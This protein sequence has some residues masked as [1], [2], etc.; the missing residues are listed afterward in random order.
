MEIQQLANHGIPSEII[1]QFKNQGFRVLTSVQSA[2]VEAGLTSGQSLVISAPTS[3]G[4]TTIAELAAIVAAQQGRRTVYLVTHRALAEEKYRHFKSTYDNG[5]DSWFDV[6]ISTGDR[7]DGD[8]QNG[9]LVATYEKFLSLVATG[10]IKNY[11]KLVVVADEIQTISAPSRGADIEIL[12][13]ILLHAKPAQFIGLTATAPNVDELAEWLGCISC[14]VDIRDVPLDQEI[15]FAGKVSGCE[16]GHGEV[17]DRDRDVPNPCGSIQAVRAL[18]DSG[19]GP[20]LVFCM[21]K[22]RAEQLATEFSGLS[23]RNQGA[24]EVSR[25]LDLFTEPTALG[26]RL[27]A[28]TASRTAFHTADLSFSERAVV[29]EALRDGH[30]DVVFATP[31]LAAGVNLPIRSVVFDSFQRPWMDEP[32]LSQSE[33]ANM[34]GRAGRLG[35]HDRGSM[36]M[37][38]TNRTEYAKAYQYVVDQPEPV[39]SVLMGSSIRK[40]IL[41]L[42]SCGVCSGDSAVVDFFERTLWYQQTVVSNNTLAKQLAVRVKEAVDWLVEND[43]AKQEGD[44]LVAT[45]FGRAVSMTGLL[46]S[47]AISFLK[48]AMLIDPEDFD[49]RAFGLIHLACASDE[50]SNEIGQR[51]LPYA[52]QTSPMAYKTVRA[53]SLFVDPDVLPNQPQV[54]NAAL[55][56]SMWGN[57]ASE[58]DLLRAVPAIRY[59]MLQVL[60]QDVAWIF[61]GMASLLASPAVDSDRRLV[62][63]FELLAKRIR[64]G[65]TLSAVDVLNAAKD[66]NVPGFGRYRAMALANADISE[67][68]KLLTAK[69]DLL[70][71]LVESVARAELLVEAVAKYFSRPMEY[72]KNRQTAAAYEMRADV[73]LIESLYEQDGVA[74]EDLV[75]ELF[76][77]LDFSPDKYDDGKRQGVPDIRLRLDCGDVYVECKSREKKKNSPISTDDAYAVF[78]KANDLS[79]AHCVTVGKPDFNSHAKKKATSAGSITLVSHKALVQAYLAYFSKKVPKHKIEEWLCTPGVATFFEL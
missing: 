77:R 18:V 62:T 11:S 74:Y 20:V 28:A 60:A 6:S 17:F 33:F 24:L 43:L 5:Q 57:G 29:E 19:L 69:P 52:R 63:E 12:C 34:S 4:K 26:E 36:V 37:L 27:K 79:A 40:P 76:R 53:Q 68:S 8:W 59:G 67:P 50:F 47:T 3:S 42:L 70:S 13:T 48:H 35:Y 14:K 49:D 45:E 25:Q 54:D 78:A 58:P 22:P 61:D 56:I 23:V 71:R 32:W 1:E 39:R 41:Q 66:A 64:L 9:I 75:F 65:V 46:P 7:S 30:I 2:C 55:A 73:E 38:P 51:F 15:W 72:W 10:A 16:S 44:L 31:T 21:T